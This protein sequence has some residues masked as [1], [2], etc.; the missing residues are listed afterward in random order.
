M[1]PRLVLNSR[2]FYLSLLRAGIASLLHH[3]QPGDA[4]FDSL[5]GERRK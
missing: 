3:R 2:F 4:A 5:G 1:L